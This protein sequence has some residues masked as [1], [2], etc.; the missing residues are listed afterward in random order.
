MSQECPGYR[1]K[2]DLI[3]RDQTKQ[4]VQRAKQADMMKINQ[5][6]H[7]PSTARSQNELR[8]PPLLQAV[9]G[10]AMVS[11]QL[12]SS[13]LDDYFPRRVK[14]N[15]VVNLTYPIISSIY[16][17][18]QKSLML[19]RA[20]SALSC[21][22]LGKIHG[23]EPFL[24]YGISLYNGAI[25]EMSKALSRRDYSADL[26]YTCAVFEQIEVRNTWLVNEK[27]ILLT[28]I[29]IHHCPDSLDKWYAHI[30]GLSAI[31]RLYQPKKGDSP[32]MD[33]I[34]GQHQKFRVVRE[35]FRKSVSLIYRQPNYTASSSSQ[36]LCVCQSQSF[37][38]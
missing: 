3:F 17:L 37:G 36:G 33:L 25:H 16:T 21:I 30:D 35:S 8:Q 6:S 15:C 14:P 7:S 29:Q 22:F 26:V 9:P 23:D 11:S 19:Q 10:G 27:Q 4:T 1:D 24:R 32:V 38:G 34:Y 5:P 2:W 13:Y 18:P 12:F 20:T 31:M 28:N